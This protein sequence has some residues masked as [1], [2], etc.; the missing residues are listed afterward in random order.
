MMTTPNGVPNTGSK[1]AAGSRKGQRLPAWLALSLAMV[2][3]VLVY[4]AL[5]P[6]PPSA[7]DRPEAQVNSP[8]NPWDAPRAF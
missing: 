5:K 3:G 1:R 2:M 7:F 4:G 6:K 8:R